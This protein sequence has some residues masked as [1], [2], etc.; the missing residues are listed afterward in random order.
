MAVKTFSGS[1]QEDAF[2]REKTELLRLLAEAPGLCDEFEVVQHQSTASTHRQS[3]ISPWL[4][5]LHTK[6]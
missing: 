6:I 5:F 4:F 1:W 3:I 2:E